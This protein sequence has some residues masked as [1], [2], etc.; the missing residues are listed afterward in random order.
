MTIAESAAATTAATKT[1]TTTVTAITT[2]ATEIKRLKLGMLAATYKS[3]QL[4][5]DRIEN[6]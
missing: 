2:T 5:D 3:K 4:A 6:L 1:I